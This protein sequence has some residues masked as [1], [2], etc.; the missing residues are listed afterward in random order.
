[1]SS[2]R[3]RTTAL[4][5]LAIAI[6]YLA[7][8]TYMYAFQREIMYNA[9]GGAAEVLRGV[10]G[11]TVETVTMDDGTNVAVW[12]AEPA[13]PDLPTVLY[14]HGN[15][16][17]LADREPRQ[18]Q[19]LDSGFGL[20]APTY[21]GYPGSEGT[22]SEAVFIADGLAHFDRLAEDGRPIVLLG[23]SLGTGVATAVAARRE[24]EALVLE[25]PYT[26]TVDVAAARYP[27]LP[28]RLLMIDQFVSRD[29]IGDVTE[30][31]LIL[32]GTDDRTTPF[33]QGRALYELANEPKEM[34][35]VENAGHN[36]LWKRGLWNH[37]QDF[38]E[39]RSEPTS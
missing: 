6:P 3:L 19:I 36:D 8:M 31:V 38:L 32:H 17:N 26:A 23:E 30:P 13:D 9:G 34:V 35:V 14:F 5:L 18:R 15:S 33:A 12:R 25:A 28:V 39:R 10:E 20:Y 7:V 16:G 2:R 21:R 22:P 1:M 27:W 4:I 11:V 37:V 29:R 24:A